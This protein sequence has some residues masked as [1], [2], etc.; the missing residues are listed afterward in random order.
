[1]RL[2]VIATF[3]GNDTTIIDNFQGVADYKR[4][5]IRIDKWKRFHMV[6]HQGAAGGM[7]AGR[8]RR[9]RADWVDPGHAE[10]ART[11]RVIDQEMTG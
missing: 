6:A 4:V 1:V 9:N 7:A 3:A 5:S 10:Q 2:S 8:G 11:K